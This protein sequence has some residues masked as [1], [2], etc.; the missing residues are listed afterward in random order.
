MAPRG[1]G[2]VEQIYGT[3]LRAWS[4]L[5]WLAVLWHVAVAVAA[6]EQLTDPG[7]QVLYGQRIKCC[8]AVTNMRCLSLLA[9]CLHVPVSI[10]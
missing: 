2:T 10:R 6:L 5:L 4:G 9:C 1:Y 3:L 7:M 8:S